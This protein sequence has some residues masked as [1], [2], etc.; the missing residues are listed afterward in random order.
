MSEQRLLPLEQ[1]FYLPKPCL[2]F[3]YLD[4]LFNMAIKKYMLEHAPMP[5]GY[6]ATYPDFL[7][8]GLI[9]AFALI[10]IGGVKLSSGVNIAIATLNVAVITFIIGQLHLN[11]RSSLSYQ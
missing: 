8:A 11:T 7:A 6:V 5:G 3:R 10:L 1:Y 9:L 2:F 4:G